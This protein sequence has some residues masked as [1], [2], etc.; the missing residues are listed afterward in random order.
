M[1]EGYAPTR[2]EIFILQV[3][4]KLYEQQKYMYNNKTHVT[5]KRIVS[6]SQHWLRPNY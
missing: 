2:K 6:L 1:S 5:E 3:I 4:M